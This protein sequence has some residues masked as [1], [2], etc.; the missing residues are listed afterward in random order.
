M[1]YQDKIYL[2]LNDERAESIPILDIL[3]VIFI[4]EEAEEDVLS[5]DELPTAVI[6]AD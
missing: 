1:S 4:L 3:T 2:V 5:T 6:R